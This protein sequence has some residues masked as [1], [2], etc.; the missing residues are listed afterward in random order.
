MCPG[1]YSHAEPCQPRWEGTDRFQGVIVHP[2]R[3]PGDLDLAGKRVVVIGSGAT[4]ATL[5]P[6]IAGEAAHVTMPQR[7]PSCFYAPPATREL[8]VT[9]RALD[10]PGDWTHEIVR[11]QSIWQ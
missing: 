8:A 5:I 4:A 3:W 6:A 9:L 2:R 1:Y 11:R 10:I 7:S